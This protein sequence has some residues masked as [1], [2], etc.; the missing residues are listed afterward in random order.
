[1]A[2]NWL[3]Q[4]ILQRNSLSW[5]TYS[6]LL[7]L[8]LKKRKAFIGHG[9]QL[10]KNKGRH[11][12]LPGVNRVIKKHSVWWQQLQRNP[13][14]KSSSKHPFPIPWCHLGLCGRNTPQ[15][16]CG[17]D[18]ASVRSQR[19]TTEAFDGAASALF[20]HA[21]RCLRR[22]SSLTRSKFSAK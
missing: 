9:A 1:M 6:L 8:L 17:A 3:K 21:V 16:K 5:Q 14:R 7:C 11:I 10:R 19:E 2:N 22:L 15:L 13:S 12:S 4:T 20:H 18:S